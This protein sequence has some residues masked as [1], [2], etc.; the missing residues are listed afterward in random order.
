[1][2][3]YWSEI[4]LDLFRLF[5]DFLKNKKAKSY[6]NNHSFNRLVKNLKIELFWL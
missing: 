1:M 3:V 6:Y 2:C 5:C 4:C